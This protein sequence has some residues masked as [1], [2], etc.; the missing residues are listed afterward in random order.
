M[1]PD[2]DKSTWTQIADENKLPNAVVVETG[3]ETRF[4]SVKNGLQLIPDGCVVAIH[5]GVRPLVTPEMIGA[6]FKLARLHGSA[7]AAVPLK[8]SLRVIKVVDSS[9]RETQAV[10]RSHYRLIQTPQTF[11]SGLIKKAYSIPEDPSLTDDASVAEK[12]GHRVF[13][14]EGHYN[15]IKIT[16]REDLLIAESLLKGNSGL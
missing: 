10:D 11:A 8:E 12:A 16:N 9:D 1:L 13:L 6:S 7:I 5:D 3:G 15:N 4:Q 2:G 14:F